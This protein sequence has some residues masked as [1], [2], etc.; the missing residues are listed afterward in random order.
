MAISKW[1]VVVDDER[2]DVAITIQVNQHLNTDQ[3]LHYEQHWM[4]VLFTVSRRFVMRC[5]N[6]GRANF[7]PGELIPTH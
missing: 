4:V 7:S 6:G 3:L 1:R 2:L 5:G